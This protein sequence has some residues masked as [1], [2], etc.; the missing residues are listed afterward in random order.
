MFSQYL[1]QFRREFCQNNGS[2]ITRLPQVLTRA[3]G[4][5][6]SAFKHLLDL[7]NNKEGLC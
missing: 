5:F 3:V 7:S 6:L 2:C 4:D 1:D